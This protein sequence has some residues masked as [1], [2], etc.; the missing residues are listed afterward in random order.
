MLFQ[1]TYETDTKS[2]QVG[3]VPTNW[4]R[5]DE[6]IY[7]SIKYSSTIHDTQTKEKSV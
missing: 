4:N 5:H 2:K 7:V 1:Y 3:N 6:S